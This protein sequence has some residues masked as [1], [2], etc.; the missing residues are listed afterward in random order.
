MLRCDGQFAQAAGQFHVG[1]IHPIGALARGGPVAE[2]S[3]HGSGP[4]ALNLRHQVRTEADQDRLETDFF[5]ALFNQ[6]IE[7][8]LL[9]RTGD[10]VS[11]LPATTHVLLGCRSCGWLGSPRW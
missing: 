6:G 10:A 3:D 11:H 4:D 2:R 5:L 8:R 1:W 7:E 9:N